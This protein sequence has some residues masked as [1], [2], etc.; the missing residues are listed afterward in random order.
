MVKLFASILACDSAYLGENVRC[1]ERAGANCVH[2]DIMDGRYVDNITFGP[3]TVKDLRKVTRLPIEVHLEMYEPERYL[4]MFVNA[5]ADRLVV[6]RETCANPIRVLNQIRELG[7]QA[8][9]AVSPSNELTSLKYL[10]KCLDFTVIMGV[11]PG[12]GGQAFERS[13]FDKIK[14][15]KQMMK[16]QDIKVPIAVDGGINIEIGNKLKSI[17]ADILIVGSGLFQTEDIFETAQ[18]FLK[19]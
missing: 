9:M 8:G 11:E 6:Q 10:L 1:A 17:G 19:D 5:G 14:T 2:I 7:M 4:N 12:F 16:E 13:C 15:L 3:Q 18:S